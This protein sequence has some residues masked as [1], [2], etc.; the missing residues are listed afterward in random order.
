M[1]YPGG[2][3][4]CGELGSILLETTLVAPVAIL[5]I[6]FVAFAG[7]VSTIQNG[8]AETARD[9]ARAASFTRSSSAAQPA[10][11][12]ATATALSTYGVSCATQHV[13]VNLSGFG[14]GGEVTVTVS[15]DVPLADLGLLGV[16]GTKTVVGTSTSVIDTARAS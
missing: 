12:A 10:A 13:A 7:R 16:S 11:D 2:R 6:L 8:V 9:A 1:A 3:R 5:L 4:G 15:C 14:P